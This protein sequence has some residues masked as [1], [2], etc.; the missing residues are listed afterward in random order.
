M[1]NDW[2]FELR[3]DLHRSKASGDA[4][5]SILDLGSIPNQLANGAPLLLGHAFELLLKLW[6]E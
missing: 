3:H 6:E 1:G 4:A 5:D 2:R